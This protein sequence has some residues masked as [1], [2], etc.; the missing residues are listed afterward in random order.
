MGFKPT[1]N[2]KQ[3]FFSK[4]LIDDKQAQGDFETAGTN[5]PAKTQFPLCS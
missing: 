4:M 2:K 1:P 5:N 3:L